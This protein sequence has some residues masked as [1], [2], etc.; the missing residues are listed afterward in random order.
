MRRNIFDTKRKFLELVKAVVE[1][2]SVA[3]CRSGVSVVDLV[4]T[5]EPTHK[6]V[7]R[8]PKGQIHSNDP[9]WWKPIDGQ[10]V[11][12]LLTWPG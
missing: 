5:K 12:E 4:R 7:L 10:E 1:S 8:T 11:D 2:L 6:S 9:D 3:I